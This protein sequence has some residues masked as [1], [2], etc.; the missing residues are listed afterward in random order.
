[1]TYTVLVAEDNEDNREILSS[2]L[3]RNGY[4]VLEAANGYEVIEMAARDRPD[5]ILMDLMLPLLD[6]WEA[7]RRIKAQADTASTPIIAVSA[8]SQ[9]EDAQTARDAGCDAFITKPIPLAAFL[10]LIAGHLQP[11]PPTP[12]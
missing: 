7:T 3:R 12:E 5:L 11:R 8:L 6:G 4:R 2:L 1:M 10:R 9:P